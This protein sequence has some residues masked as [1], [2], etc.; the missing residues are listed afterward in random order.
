VA[1]RA[2]GVAELPDIAAAEPAA[3]E[4]LVDGAVLRALSELPPRQRAVVV[5]RFLLDLD[6][7]ATSRALDCSEGTVKSQTSHA[8]T[9]PRDRLGRLGDPGRQ[10]LRADHRSSRGPDTGADSAAG[11]VLVMLSGRQLTSNS[12]RIGERDTFSSV[13][14]VPLAQPINGATAFEVHF[15]PG[16]GWSDSTAIEF[17]SSIHVLPTARGPKA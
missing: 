1:A 5:L 16:I 11:K 15:P 12:A 4:L 9:K 7:Q 13:V 10:R 17:A 2:S 6:V 3:G 8:L 14:L